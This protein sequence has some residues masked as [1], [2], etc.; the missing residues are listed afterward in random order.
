MV[1]CCLHKMNCLLLLTAA[2]Q[3]LLLMIVFVRASLYKKEDLI[4]IS[5]LISSCSI[6]LF[7]RNQALMLYF[8]PLMPDIKQ[9]KLFEYFFVTS[10]WIDGITVVSL[11]CT[12]DCYGSKASLRTQWSNL[13]VV[14]WWKTPIIGLIFLSIMPQTH[15][16]Q[17]ASFLAVTF[18][19]TFYLDRYQGV[20][21]P[22]FHIFNGDVTLINSFAY[23]YRFNF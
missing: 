9:L 16:I 13:W 10:R 1:A 5:S 3:H 21:V 6:K 23:Y 15:T 2:A 11:P 12:V 20:Q 7:F 19:N 14:I 18:F 4:I 8:L 17:T 22:V